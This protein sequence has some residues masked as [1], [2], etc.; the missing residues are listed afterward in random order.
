MQDIDGIS[1]SDRLLKVESAT[2]ATE[3]N[4]PYESTKATATN[5]LLPESNIVTLSR[6]S[7]IVTL[8]RES[9][10]ALPIEWN[11]SRSP[12][13][14]ESVRVLIHHAGIHVHALRYIKGE[15]FL[16]IFIHTHCCLSS[17]HGSGCRVYQKLGGPR[18]R[19]ACVYDEIAI[20]ATK[21]LSNPVSKIILE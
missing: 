20:V 18:S 12:S 17:N 4:V 8:S 9:N 15:D 13:S 19:F 3:A 2:I 14:L 7:N 16:F 11:D 21:L 6:E 10:A 5:D 1:F